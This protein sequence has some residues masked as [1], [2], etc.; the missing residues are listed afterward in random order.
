METKYG[1]LEADLTTIIQT[2]RKYPSVESAY[3]FGSR[4]KGDFRKGSDVDIA[5][6]GKALNFET[7][8]QISYWL[9]EETTMPYR[10][11]IVNYHSVHN[12]ALL[13]HI[14]R[15]G[16]ELYTKEDNTP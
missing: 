9:N 5:L 2:L 11:D 6:K 10:F 16:L 8:S 14:D 13:A 12:D 1:L 7:L 15:I 3:L 4:A